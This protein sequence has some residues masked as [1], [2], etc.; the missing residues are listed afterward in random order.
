MAHLNANLNLG[1]SSN[2]T[3]TYYCTGFPATTPPTYS[4]TATDTPNG[5]DTLTLT[6]V[7]TGSYVSGVNV[8]CATT[9]AAGNCW[10]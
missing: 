7:I 1:S 5:T 8:T 9:G 3:F 2:D 4:C 6:E 10:N